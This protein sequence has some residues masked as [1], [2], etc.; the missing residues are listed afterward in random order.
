MPNLNVQGDLLL[1]RWPPSL[2]QKHNT[3]E[4]PFL[5]TIMSNR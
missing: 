2:S 1:M 4:K 3:D 5:S